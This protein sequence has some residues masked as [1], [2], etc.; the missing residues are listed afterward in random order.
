MNYKETDD[1]WRLYRREWVTV[2]TVEGDGDPDEL[3]PAQPIYSLAT[4][5]ATANLEGRVRDEDVRVEMHTDTNTFFW[6]HI[7]VFKDNLKGEFKNVENAQ[8]YAST[9][10]FDEYVIVPRNSKSDHDIRS[11]GV[12][13]L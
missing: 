1:I 4:Q 9:N 11:Y 3:I 6:A 13:K 8:Y 2:H 12:V 5:W 7:Q 10:G